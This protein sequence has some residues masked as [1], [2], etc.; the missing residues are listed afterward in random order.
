MH[1]KNAN[2]VDAANV[3]GIGLGWRGKLTPQLQLSAT[4]R[5]AAGTLN[6]SQILGMEANV[7][8]NFQF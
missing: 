5:F 7:G 6:D 2:G 4:V 3:V 1:A 8:G